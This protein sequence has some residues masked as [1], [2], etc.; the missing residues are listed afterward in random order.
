MSCQV[1]EPK[2]DLEPANLEA[3]AP[4][5]WNSSFLS[6]LEARLLMDNTMLS[7]R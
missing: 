6:N 2:H 3:Q 4:M 7:K 1:A 5:S